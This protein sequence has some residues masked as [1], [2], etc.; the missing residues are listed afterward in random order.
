MNH[1]QGVRFEDQANYQTQLFDS[2]Q[3]AENQ[4]IAQAIAI[5]ERRHQRGQALTSS[6]VVKDYLRLRMGGYEHEVFVV[7]HLDQQHRVLDVEEMFRG[8]IDGASVYPREVVKS[9]LQKNSA[10]VILV[11]NHPS[12]VCTPS[13]ADQQITQRLKTALGTVDIRV[14][15]HFVVSAVDAVSFSERGLM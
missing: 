1:F 15:D 6:D 2:T 3:E 9:C 8:T 7:I 11:H 12:G 14:L 4:V 10:A 13:Q 5:I